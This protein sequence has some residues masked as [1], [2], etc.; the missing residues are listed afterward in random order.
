MTINQLIN[1]ETIS[2]KIKDASI[3]PVTITDWI[4]SLEIQIA[5]ILNKSF[6]IIS[7]PEGAD[8]DLILNYNDSNLYRKYLLAMIDF[9]SG[10]PDSYNVSAKDFAVDFEIFKNLCK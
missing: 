9:F 6:F 7:Y 10:N 4:N 2:Q 8:K 5:S 3:S 1:D